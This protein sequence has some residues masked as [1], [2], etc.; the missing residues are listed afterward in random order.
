MNLCYFNQIFR[1]N[2]NFIFEEIALYL[3]CDDMYKHLIEQILNH[4][5]ENNI[6][7]KRINDLENV[8]YPPSSL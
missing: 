5:K 4:E 1:I 3:K 2:K 8:C 7:R 6:F